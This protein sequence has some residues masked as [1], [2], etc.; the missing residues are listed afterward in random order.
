MTWHEVWTDITPTSFTQTADRG[1]EGGPLHRVPPYMGSESQKVAKM[2]RSNGRSETFMN[3]L[4]KHRVLVA[5]VLAPVMA[6]VLYVVVYGI[7]TQR[8][9]DL[10][11]DWFFRLCLSTLAMTVPFLFTL[12]LALSE[13]RRP[14]ISRSARVGLTFAILSLGLVW[15][16]VSDGVL[17]L[18]QSRNQAMRG[19]AAPLFES[20]DL[21]GQ[22]QRLRRPKGQGR[23]GE[24]LGNLVRPLPGGDAEARHLVW[25][26]EGARVHCLWIIR[27][28]HQ[29]AA[30]IPG[31]SSGEL[32][33]PDCEWRGAHLL[34][35]H[36]A[37]PGDVSHRSPRTVATCAHPR[38]ALREG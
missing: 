17:R 33:A 19:V 31:T 22:T 26:A 30:E 34:S 16:P 14:R 29:H 36:R 13:H 24:C 7:L 2:A 38:S 23:A 27:R 37:L 25:Y 5:G 35:G 6:V 21:T 20:T 4:S 32:P 9:R 18:K 15:K 28:G 11:G 8:S 3:R 1:E 10:E 12:A